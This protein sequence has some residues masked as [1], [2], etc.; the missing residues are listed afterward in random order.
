MSGGR[1]TKYDPKYCEMLF[2]HMS[3]GYSLE[4]FAGLIGVSRSTLY[5][6][7]ENNAE[8]SDIA[9]RSKAAQL[10]ANEQ[11]M[12]DLAKGKIRNGNTAAA[13]FLMKNYHR[14]AD[15]IEAKIED[16]TAKNIDELKREAA[17]LLAKLED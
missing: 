1:P 2:S 15:R 17:E 12:R 8:F 4:S 5:E 16:M 7:I 10:R 3:E 14:W 13:T 11:L 9:A 6:W